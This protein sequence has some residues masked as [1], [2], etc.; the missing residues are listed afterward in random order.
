VVE[1]FGLLD[2]VL[3]EY[4]RFTYRSPTGVAASF[5]YEN[6]AFVTL[7]Y[8]KA[9][10][11]MHSQL[12]KRGNTTILEKAQALGFDVEKNTRSI[13]LTLSDSTCVSCN[14]LVDASG[15][16]FF[17]SRQLGTALPSLYSHPYGEFLEGCKIEDP[18][19]MCIFAGNKYGN[20]GGW[21]YP[22]NRNTARFGFATV[23]RSHVYPRDI[24]E[25]NFKEAIRDFCPYNEMLGGARKVR[26][27]F[28][29]IPFGS[30][31]KFA[32]EQI[33]MVGDAAGH[34]TPWYGEGVR[35][36]L[37]SG[38]L[39]GKA[40]VEAYKNRML[41]RTS[42][43]RY[44]QLWDAKN[45]RIYSDALKIGFRSYFRSQKQW[46]DSVRYHATLTPKEMIELVRYRKPPSS[47]PKP[48]AIRLQFRRH[49]WNFTS[50][51]TTNVD[52]SN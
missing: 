42:L 3:Q 30:L 9:C 6:P 39:C 5:E 48:P 15:R 51:S 33:L 8:Q 10:N 32:Y 13:R 27:E 14:V 11:I 7:D 46:D 41:H 12:R 43:E 44:Q 29:T 18:K 23:T 2:A 40:I 49:L 52:G 22:I 28:G 36:A 38:E 20:G 16:D 31:G 19:E 37:E 17:A 26:S 45:R 1:H 21:L 4:T 47:Q 25:R 35:P 34:A 50:R 24:V